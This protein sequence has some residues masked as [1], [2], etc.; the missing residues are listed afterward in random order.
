M[1]GIC[2]CLNW[3][4]KYVN[5]HNAISNKKFLYELS[6]DNFYYKVL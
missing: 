2:V 6:L 3:N 4:R 1:H 5:K